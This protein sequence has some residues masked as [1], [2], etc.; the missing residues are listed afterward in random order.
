M[1]CP[2]FIIGPVL[3]KDVGASAS[4]VQR[5]LAGDMPGLLTLSFNIVHV[6][7]VAEAHV[8]ALVQPRAAGERFLLCANFRI[9]MK[10]VAAIL[11]PKYAPLVRMCAAL[12]A[13]LLHVPCLWV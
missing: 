2:A 1:I 6:D 4:L 5:L 8:R 12:V 3:G 11:R 10:D 7:N 9:W 13:W